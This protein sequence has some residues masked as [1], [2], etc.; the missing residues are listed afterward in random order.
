MS[1]FG[2]LVG[3]ALRRA[4]RPAAVWAMGGLV[5]LSLWRARDAGR[6]PAEVALSQDVADGLA[7]EALWFTALAAALAWFP[8]AAAHSVARWRRGEGEWLGTSVLRPAG[9]MAA[10]STGGALALALVLLSCAAAAEFA[11]GSSP[12]LCWL[13]DTPVDGVVLLR[14]G[15]RGSTLSSVPEGA[16]L[17]FAR[18]VVAAPDDGPPQTRV[19]CT[20]EQEGLPARTT[21]ARITGNTPIPVEVDPGSDSVRL[22]FERV[23]PGASVVL[24]GPRVEWYRAAGP[25]WEGVLAMFLHAWLALLALQGLAQAVAVW[26]SPPSAVL[27]AAVTLALAWLDGDAPRA[28]PGVGLRRALEACAD[29]HAAGAPELGPWLSTAALLGAAALCAASRRDLWRR[30]A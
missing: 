5:L 15:S 12:R 9:I 13:A 24:E 16:T 3:L 10:W 6:S 2:G 29:G 14:A 28:W 25:R 22:D 8:A 23:G 18:F 17:G 20:L 11:A 19:L 7:R 21:E 4:L 26:A 1:A 27:A 30:E